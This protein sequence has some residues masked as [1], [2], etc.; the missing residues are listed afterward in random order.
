[1]TDAQ[2]DEGGRWT[3]VGGGATRAKIEG[4]GVLRVL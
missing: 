1:M 2:Q 3:E 4:D